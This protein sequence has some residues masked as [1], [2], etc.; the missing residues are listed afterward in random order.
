MGKAKPTRLAKRCRNKPYDKYAKY[1]KLECSDEI[2]LEESDSSEEEAEEQSQ[3]QIL[4]QNEYYVALIQVYYT[5]EDNNSKSDIIS[6]RFR[7]KE[8]HQTEAATNYHSLMDQFYALLP[9]DIKLDDT[10]Q[11]VLY[12]DGSDD[13]YDIDWTE[14]S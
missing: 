13:L 1:P 9:S 7:N 3:S 14:R 2:I 8:Q 4:D 6:V 12:G 11:S 10:I 5:T